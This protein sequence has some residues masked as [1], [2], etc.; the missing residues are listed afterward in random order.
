MKSEEKMDIRER[1]SDKTYGIIGIVAFLAIIVIIAIIFIISSEQP[2]AQ[3]NATNS[4]I[5]TT[6]SQSKDNLKNKEDDNIGL[7]VS[8]SQK[9]N[10]SLSESDSTVNNSAIEEDGNEKV[11]VDDKT[12][13]EDAANEYCKER[14]EKHDNISSITYN[15]LFSTNGDTYLFEY[16]VEYSDGSTKKGTVTVVKDD[17]G[18]FIGKHL[19]IE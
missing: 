12:K 13:A 19:S 16:T 6:S 15:D 4:N 8:E 17:T 2:T 10:I 18:N 3:T 9:D 5:N 14:V 7:S 11:Q 1:I